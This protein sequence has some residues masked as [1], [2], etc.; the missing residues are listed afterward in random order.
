M[1]GLGT[2][3]LEAGQSRFKRGQAWVWE[4]VR[5]V[6]VR[7]W[8]GRQGLVG[9]ETAGASWARPAM[10]QMGF[11]SMSEIQT[12]Q[13]HMQGTQQPQHPVPP[14]SSVRGG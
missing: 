5:S 7:D 14:W 10:L 3:R 13:C 9:L 11:G 8:G 6:W 1:W 12:A 2:V 4:G